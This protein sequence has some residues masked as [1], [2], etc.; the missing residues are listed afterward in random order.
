MAYVNQ[1]QLHCINQMGKTQSKPLP[2]RHGTGMAWLRH[3]MY[4]LAF[5]W[6][7]AMFVGVP[8]M[9]LYYHNTLQT[10]K[11]V[12]T[13]HITT[14]E[15]VHKQQRKFER[16]TVCWHK[17]VAPIFI[18]QDKIVTILYKHMKDTSLLYQIVSCSS[19]SRYNIEHIY[20][21]KNHFIIFLLGC[22]KKKLFCL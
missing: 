4:E 18:L 21:L 5:N 22:N 8:L 11:N 15:I 1:T 2:A 14:N 7:S 3:G 9:I 20:Y 19:V 13:F 17:Y 12:F 16:V 6:W 10:L